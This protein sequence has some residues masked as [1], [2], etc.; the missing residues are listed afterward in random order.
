MVQ[1]Q[2]N[3]H[4][5]M[6]Q[7]GG[8]RWENAIV[9]GSVYSDLLRLGKIQDPFFRENASEALKLCDYDYEYEKTFSVG[10]C[11]AGCDRVFLHCDGLDTL[12]KIYLNGKKIAET[13]NMHRT[14][15]F[16]VT[17]DLLEG[18]NT[19]RIHFLSPNRYVEKMQKRN[20]L[21]NGTLVYR[22]GVS[23][24]R[25]AHYMFGWDWGPAL[26]DMGIWRDIY[27]C[28]FKT[29]KIKS[30]AVRQDHRKDF[31]RLNILTKLEKYTKGKLTVSATV[32]APNGEKFSSDTETAGSSASLQVDILRPQLW[33]PNGMGEHPLYSVEISVKKGENLLDVRS[34]KIGLRT[35]RLKQRK[36]RWGK[37]FCLSV[38]GK[39]LFAMG[40]NYIPEDNILSRRSR[41]RTEK[42]IRDCVRSNF[43]LLRVW[44][45]GFYPDDYFYDLCDENGILVWQDFMFACGIYDFSPSFRENVEKE[46]IDVL[47]RIRHHACLALLCG[48]NEQEWQWTKDDPFLRA[49][50]KLKADYIRQFETFMPE[51]AHRYAPDIP[52]WSASP[53]SYGSFD[54]PNG[55][56]A[57][58]MHYWEV[59]H[60]RRP[61]TDYRKVFPRF[62][63]EFGLQSFPSLKT[64]KSFTEPADL[65]PFSPVMEAH[66]KDP[67]G[68]E[69]ILSYIAQYCRYPKDFDSLLYV[70]QVVQAEGIRY[71]VEH[72]RRLRG[73]CMGT[74]YWQLNDCWPAISWSSIDY[75][76]RW[77]ALQYFA[78]RFFSPVLVSAEENAS[79]VVL[80]VTNDTGNALVGT[81]IWKLRKQDGTILAQNQQKV[82]IPAF[83][84]RQASALDFTEY[85]R[86]F[87]EQRSVYLQYELETAGNT[88]GAGTVL[89]VPPK[90]FD[91]TNPQLHCTVTEREDRFIITVSAKA[92][93]KS[94]ELDLHNADAVFSDNYFDLS[95]GETRQIDV[96][97]E[98]L[99]TPL[100]CAQFK[101]QLKIRSLYD[102]YSHF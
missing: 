93:A 66:Q 31:V 41:E 65:N 78:R 4:W 47:R 101:E 8:K 69:K 49:N 88:V 82:E 77:K 10:N 26:P 18:Q 56:S 51:V 67:S 39:D 73:R 102:S 94:V 17:K 95:A 3:G 71:G 38:N 53:S 16:D 13:C 74:V 100:T 72:F 36:D 54:E 76:G 37:S 12:C 43:N 44:G 22:G 14:Y 35:I 5:L 84:S 85:L 19:L 87:E 55:E 81:L 23:Y 61:I 96:K 25:K 91:F 50:P 21:V 45:G 79:S 20:P 29:A 24:L 32:T 1:Y 46:M 52:Y 9:P 80:S 27:L 34:A 6:R 15:D 63:S 59:W 57:G 62:M 40:A 33:W 99:S 58:D 2:L 92:F 64:V 11:F 75:F 97:K 68:N 30:W 86:S 28:G 60:G 83:A 70:S 42:I 48:N 90:Y 89:F 98:D 7:K